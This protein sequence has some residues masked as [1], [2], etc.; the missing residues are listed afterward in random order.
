MPAFDL[1]NLPERE[2]DID[3]SDIEEKYQVP[4]EDGYDTLIVVD[5]L[6]IVEAAKEEKLLAVIKRIFRAVGDVKE[7]G[8]WMP[9]ELNEKGQRMNKGYL[10]IDYETAEAAVAAVKT[11]DNYRMDKNHALSVN[12][13][14]DV[15]KYSQIPDEYTPPP[16]E[17]FIEKEHLRSWLT[18]PQA[19][20]QW[21]LYRADDVSIFWNMKTEAPEHVYSRT[22]WTETYVQWSPLGTYLTAFHRQG[23]TIWGGP[24]WN[25]INRFVHPG[26]KLI[27]FSPNEH[28]VV[29]W[30]NEPI[31][32][33]KIPDGTPSP[34]SEEDEGNQVAIWDV[35]SGLLLRSFPVV[36]SGDSPK[37][38]TWPMFK[39]SPSDKYFARV[40]PAQLISVYETPDMGLVG[41]KSIKIEGV[42][43][44]EW[45]PAR[46]DGDDKKTNQKEE[47]LSYWTPEIGN[48]P[49]RVTLLAIP[50]KE[51][52]RTK[53]LFSVNECKLHWQ[54][55]GA[56]LAVKVDRH[57]KT[58]KSTFTNL[59]VFRIGEKDIP[60]ETIEVKEPVIAFA[61]EP[62]GER[63]AVITTADP[64]A[65]Q[66]APGAAAGA[67]AQAP[68]TLR[69][70]VTF[71][72]LDTS[73]SVAA[74]KAMKTLEKKSCNNIFWSPKGRHLVLATLRST[75]TWDLEFWD[76]DFEGPAEGAKKVDLSKAEDVGASI[77]LLV[78][79]DHYGVTDVEWDPTGRFVVTGA[80]MWRPTVADH[81]YCVWDFKGQLLYKQ[82]ID[83]FKQLL[84][85]PRPRTLLSKEMMKKIRKNL[86]SYSVIFEEED[87]GL[88]KT[89]NIEVLE[90]R[91]RLFDEW[92]NWRK[93]VEAQLAE[94]RKKT[95]MEVRR[96][97]GEDDDDDIV[98]EMIEEVIEEFEEVVAE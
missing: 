19:R 9:T 80:S 76:L 72:Y 4:Y 67:S 81:G 14:T 31:S 77:Q 5:N 27:D 32:L 97:A 68:Q 29:T 59:E 63:F 17:E 38:I 44:F 45:S 73:K 89:I 7:G 36:Q 22:N 69:T 16:E 70:N 65:G 30:S 48:Q 95:G 37:A 51:I 3:F 15:E 10:F 87:A 20:D 78:T 35:H 58:K 88:I 12:R 2:E 28:Y 91:R 54:S 84:W 62:A 66:P 71:Y 40:T 34:F 83:K 47:V 42:M 50:S 52:V 39:W 85:R 53:N 55:Q 18:D 6:P 79:R 74:F 41:K 93:R 60:V 90:H 1:D 92:Y 24:S 8:V 11:L 26:V 21:V 82:N 25:K 13:F 94:E 43:D 49:A 46:P 57:T 64:G 61:W 86:R 75:T 56:Y 23:I 33:A 96:G 98:E